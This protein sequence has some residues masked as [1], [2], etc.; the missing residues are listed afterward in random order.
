MPVQQQ[1]A[2]TRIASI[3]R[4]A[5]L[6]RRRGCGN[7]RGTLRV[8]LRL[9]PS[10]QL[11]RLHGRRGCYCECA[12]VRRGLRVTVGRGGGGGGVA[13]LRG[14]RRPRRL[15]L[16]ALGARCRAR[17]TDGLQQHTE[18]DTCAVWTEL[19]T[20]PQAVSGADVPKQAGSGR[21]ALV[22]W[23]TADSR[24]QRDPWGGRKGNIARLSQKQG[25]YKKA[26]RRTSKQLQAVSWTLYGVATVVVHWGRGARARRP[27]PQS[28]A[29]WPARRCPGAVSGAASAPPPAWPGAAAATAARAPHCPAPAPPPPAARPWLNVRRVYR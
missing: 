15:R 6:G 5:L 27:L 14:R 10:L 1:A 18:G 24:D 4:P 29:R 9:C 7:R 23:L 25:G 3:V 16:L 28:P 12:R 21:P 22:G 19:L 26:R 8:I 17:P 13:A 20:T 2:A 11:S